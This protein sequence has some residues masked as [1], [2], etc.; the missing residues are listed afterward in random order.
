[1]AMAFT[2]HCHITN[3]C[4]KLRLTLEQKFVVKDSVKRFEEEGCQREIT[5]FLRFKFHANLLKPRILDQ[6]FFKLFQN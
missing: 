4:S 5:H 1:M 2:K 3:L 6:T